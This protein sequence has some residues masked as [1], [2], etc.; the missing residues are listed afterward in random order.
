MYLLWHLFSNPRL[1]IIIE[2]PEG[3]LQ[4]H[5]VSSLF[6]TVLCLDQMDISYCHFGDEENPCPR[7]NTIL[8][9]NSNMLKQVIGPGHLRCKKN[10]RGMTANGREH[11]VKVQDFPDRCSAY[12]KEMCSFLAQLL[13]IDVRAKQGQP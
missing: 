13:A 6:K 5:P 11:M 4:L 3:Y 7:K 1:I 12:P 9:T 8:W 2:N 10:C